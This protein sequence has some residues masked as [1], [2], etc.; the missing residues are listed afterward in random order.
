V[1]DFSLRPLFYRAAIVLSSKLPADS[2]R[3]NLIH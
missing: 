2:R 1:S 3:F